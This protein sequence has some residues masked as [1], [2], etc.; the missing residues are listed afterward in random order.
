MIFSFLLTIV[1]AF[2]G[3]AHSMPPIYYFLIVGM[4]F[5]VIIKEEWD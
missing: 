1:L 2:M 3:A 4:L 5:C